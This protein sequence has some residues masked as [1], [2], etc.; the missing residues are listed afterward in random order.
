MSAIAYDCNF[1]FYFFGLASVGGIL[2]GAI[3]PC[4]IGWYT[5]TTLLWYCYWLLWAVRYLHLL[6]CV[7]TLKEGDR[8]ELFAFA[9]HYNADVF[10]QL[11]IHKLLISI[12]V[13]GA[14]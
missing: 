1:Q 9:L 13:E 6:G 12:N 3:I 10:F 4:L 14:L 7:E 2:V 11:E 5:D 8:Y